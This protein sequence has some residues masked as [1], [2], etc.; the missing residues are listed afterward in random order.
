MPP[1]GAA[2]QPW[3]LHHV[4]AST[5]TRNAAAGAWLADRTEEGG[6]SLLISHRLK[7]VHGGVARLSHTLEVL[8]LV[9]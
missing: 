5:P 8:L 1:G 2:R 7:Q 6:S 3:L 9:R 4:K